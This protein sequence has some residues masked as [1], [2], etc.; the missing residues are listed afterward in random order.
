MVDISQQETIQTP[1]VTAALPPTPTFPQTQV[2]VHENG[3]LITTQ[4]APYTQF[5]QF[6]PEDMMNQVAG[7]WLETRKELKRKLE[8]V[9]DLKR[10]NTLS[11][12]H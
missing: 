5:V 4:L 10:S 8:I 12:R 9:H 6:L 11:T 1:T 7:K 2:N 3:V